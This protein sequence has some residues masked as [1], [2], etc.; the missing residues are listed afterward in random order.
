MF[1]PGGNRVYPIPGRIRS[2]TFGARTSNMDID[3]IKQLINGK[4]V[5]LYKA[6]LKES[7]FG[8]KLEKYGNKI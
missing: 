3:I 8:I 4:N 6:V 1:M 7:E 2:I 5:S